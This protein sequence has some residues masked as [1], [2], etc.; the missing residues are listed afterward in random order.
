MA[1]IAQLKTPGADSHPLRAFTL[2]ELLVVV[3]IIAI[4]AGLLLPSLSQSKAAAQR[5]NCLSNLRQMAMAANSFVMDEADAYPAAYYFVFEN[6]V[7]YAYGWDLTTVRGVTNAVIPGL[8]WQGGGIDKIQ[9]CPAFKG[10]ANWLVDPYTGYNYNTSF[11]GH[12]Q[13]EA[14]PEPAKASAVR[15]PVAT[16]IF[17]DGQ[18]ASGANKFMRAPWR[19]PGD[20]TFNGRWSGT[21]GFR[22]L[23]RSNAAFC[24]GHVDSL[25]N[26]FVENQDGAAKVAPGTGFLTTDNSIYD[27]E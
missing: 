25:R 3:A 2:I 17:G 1:P 10:S 8:L 4:L 9:Q 23:G 14:I 12:G 16:V 7:S 15:Q 27:L 24:D 21:Q 11:I 18:Y 5:V 26:R 6:D 19:N 20:A 22:H 13:D